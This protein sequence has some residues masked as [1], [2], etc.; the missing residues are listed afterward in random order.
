MTRRIVSAELVGRADAVEQVLA[1]FASAEAGEPRHGLVS[2]EAGVGKTRL[3][4]RTGELVGERGARVLL[5]GCVSMGDA[6]LPFAPYAEIV[7][8]LV[9]QD[10]VAKTAALAGRSAEDL[11]RLV[12]SLSSGD[13]T[14]KQELWAQS[15]LYESLLELFQRLAA[16]EPLLIQLEDLH[17][18][19]AGTLAATAF[20]FRAIRDEPIVIVC[21]IRSDEVTRRHPLRPWIAEVGRSGRVERMDL[22]RLTAT[23]SAELVRN[24]TGTDQPAAALVDIHRRSDG[25]PFFVEELLASGADEDRF[26]PLSLRDVL[27]TRVDAMEPSAQELL[28]VAAIGGREVDHDMLLAVAGRSDTS[29]TKDLAALVEASLV[30]PL[31]ASGRDG[32]AFRHALVQEAVHDAL[33]PPQRRRLHREYAERLEQRG[34][35]ASGDVRLLV[36][37]AQHW[38][39]ARDDRALDASIRAGDAAMTSY[40]FSTAAQEYDHALDLWA[41]TV[42]VGDDAIDH[43]DLLAKEGRAASYA[44]DS[45]R[46]V[47]VA[48]Q[49]MSE[50]ADDAD[51]ARCSKLGLRLARALWNSGDWSAS[52]EAYEEA[53]TAAP[54][55]PHLSRIHALAGLGQA[56]M[57]FGWPSRSRPL[58]GEAI[59]LAR[60]VGARDL[61]SHGLTTLAMD[62]AGM[63]ESEAAIEAIDRAL[64]IAIEL[65]LPGH[66]GRAYADKGDVLAWS[67]YPERALESSRVGIKTAIDLGMEISYGTFIRLGAVSFAYLVGEWGEAA[68]LL[69]AADHSGDMSVGTEAY[70]AEYAL[71]FLVSSGAPD[72][73]AVWRKAR[74]MYS[75]HPGNASSIPTFVAAIEAACFEERFED[76][77]ELADEGLELLRKIDGFNRVDDLARAASRPLAE[78]GRRAAMA[79]DHEAFVAA[80]DRLDSLIETMRVSRARMAMPTVALDA[81]LDAQ[82]AQV[83]MERQRLSGD[84]TV[85][86]WR[87][88]AARWH[89]IGYPY[90]EAYPLWRAA[91]AADSSGERKAAVGALKD[92]HAIAA[93][94][95]ARPLMIQ[96]DV[97]ARKLRV[98]LDAKA[99]AEASAPIGAD[100]GLTSREREVLSLVTAGRTN[101]Q[102]AEELFISESTAGVHVSNILSKLGVSSR[103]QAA[104]VSISQGLVEPS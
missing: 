103:T 83:H 96:L 10:G 38:R 43:I 9:A 102:I 53:L 88:V 4:T 28:S 94:L 84:A 48:R 61:E 36:Q 19:D 75:E 60:S 100:F 82:E 93:R 58:C 21:T 74:Q 65:G 15:R 32:W 67:G 33:L 95:G 18:A 40:A 78:V 12:P 46:A 16:R 85:E 91:Q 45:R 50:L 17:W 34:D 56:Y 62:L 39:E 87:A 101:R 29:S 69:A 41:D 1:A 35:A 99:V 97:V 8:R 72:A 86:G 20:L 2:G 81:V 3:L 24:I 55:R 44:G 68:E 11:A 42:T 90:L 14:P 76:A 104:T 7:R 26:L 66:I 23:E 31:A 47:T 73:A 51:P 92:A 64:D 98:R 30:V 79:N 49:A 13:E 77:V 63:G 6:A 71:G 80:R 57:L 5:G 27:L 70:R 37:L 25:N 59:E 89:A 52:L 54:P 22:E